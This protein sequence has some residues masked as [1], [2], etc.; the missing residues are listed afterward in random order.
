MRHYF[1]LP[2]TMSGLPRSVTA[3]APARPLV[4]RTRLAHALAATYR[5][6]LALAVQLPAV[7]APA[8]FHLRVASLAIEQPERIADR[9]LRP[10]DFWIPK[11]R[12]AKLPPQLIAVGKARVAS[13]AFHL[14]EQRDHPGYC[15]IW[16]TSGLATGP[17]QFRASHVRH[18]GLRRRYDRMHAV[19]GDH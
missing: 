18:S 12:S 2:R 5:S 9:G 1:P 11:P 13:R 8:E 15:R 10:A 17:A 14:S 3:R 16:P 19:R 7:T 6:A 4:A